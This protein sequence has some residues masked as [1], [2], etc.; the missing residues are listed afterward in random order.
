MHRSKGRTG[1][2]EDLLI[3]RPKAWKQLIRVS[4]KASVA[5][6]EQEKK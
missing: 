4:E 1:Q 3:P 6:I 2:I 5:G